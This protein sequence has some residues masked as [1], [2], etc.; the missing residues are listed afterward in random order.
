LVQRTL[1]QTAAASGVGLHSGETASLSLEPATADSGIV[2]VCRDRNGIWRDVPAHWR[3]ARRDAKLA[4][5]IEGEN[6][7]AVHTVEHL[8]AALAGLGI[9]NL[10]IV[11]EGPEIPVLD[12]SALPFI[13]LIEAAGI[14]EQPAPRRVFEILRPVQV[15]RGR[16]STALRPSPDFGIAMTI[17]FPHPCIARQSVEIACDRESFRSEL[18]PA[19]TFGMFADVERLHAAGLARG[20]SF[21]NAV[22]VGADGVMN[23]EGLRF[24]DEFVR[25][26]A[27]DA[28]GDLLLAGAPVIGAFTGIRSGHAL[29]IA[30]LEAVFSTRDAWVVREEHAGVKVPLAAAE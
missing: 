16:A 15:E 20:G 19:R 18:A 26:K 12:G 28:L 2:F 14:A 6:G 9:D 10:R 13:E 22:V 7:A 24:P 8:L 30:L 23:A 1:R 5:C 11:V 3:H 27:L 4:T 25:H 29:N 17:E 21:D